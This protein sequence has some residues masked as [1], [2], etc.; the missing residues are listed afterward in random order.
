VQLVISVDPVVSD[1]GAVS[2]AFGPAGVISTASGPA[3]LSSPIPN[4]KITFVSPRHTLLDHLL[5]MFHTF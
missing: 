5:C 1:A 4:C 3:V 2:T